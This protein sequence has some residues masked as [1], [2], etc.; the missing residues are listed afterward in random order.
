MKLPPLDPVSQKVLYRVLRSTAAPVLH[1]QCTWDHPQRGL[2]APGEKNIEIREELLS[3]KDCST[4]PKE[5]WALQVSHFH[6]S[7]HHITILAGY[8]LL[9]GT[10]SFS[11]S[12]GGG[13]HLHPTLTCCEPLCDCLPAEALI[14]AQSG[15]LTCGLPCHHWKFQTLQYY[16]DHNI[17]FRAT[18]HIC[19]GGSYNTKHELILFLN[20]SSS[21]KHLAFLRFNCSIHCL[22]SFV[23]QKEVPISLGAQGKHAVVFMW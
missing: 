13:G 12:V 9:L 10:R 21:V 4:S 3:Q 23:L 15:Y 17:H 2:M 1:Y 11:S 5:E 16:A 20:D 19:G 14:L 18:Q 7:P 8:R 6:I 22:T